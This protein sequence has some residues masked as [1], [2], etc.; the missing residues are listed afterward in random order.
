MNGSKFKTIVVGVDFSDYSK[1]VVKQAAKLAEIYG[2][3]LIFVHSLSFTIY[4]SSY[5]MFTDFMRDVVEPIKAEIRSFYRQKDLAQSEVVVEVGTASEVII[6]IA[7]A[8]ENPLIVVGHKGQSG[9]GRF[10]L[11]S[12]AERLALHSPFPVWVHR[13]NSVRV[14]K[15]I[16]L[17]CDFSQRT[18]TSFNIANDISNGEKTK[19]EFFHVQQMPVPI[20]DVVGFRAAMKKFSAYESRKKREFKISFPKVPL[21]ASVGE[22]AS[23]IEKESKKFDLIA[24]A[25]HSREGVFSNFGSVTAKVVRNGDVPVLI[26]H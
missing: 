3:K 24:M 25:P 16:L 8:S 21:K 15:K 23:S 18:Q 20:L 11:G 10:F 13:G 4:S 17:P 6:R 14:P 26:T 9:L 12:N 7:K 22:P 1:I 19:L 5:Q 2:A